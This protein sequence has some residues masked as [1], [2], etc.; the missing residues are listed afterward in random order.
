MRRCIRTGSVSVCRKK[1]QPDNHTVSHWA[2][3]IPGFTTA[4]LLG[5]LEETYRVWRGTI[6]IYFPGQYL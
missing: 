5:C 6:A 2:F 1:G 3:H 4:G